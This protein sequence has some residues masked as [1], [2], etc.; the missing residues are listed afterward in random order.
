[1]LKV[2]AAALPNVL[3]LP[4]GAGGGLLLL[5]LPNVLVVEG[6]PNV[7][8]PP[9]VF[10]EGVLNVPNVEVGAGVLG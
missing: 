9:K 10:V 7:V 6:V 5:K 8:P 4:K 2:L 1:V 3:G